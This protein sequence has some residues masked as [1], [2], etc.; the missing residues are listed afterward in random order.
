MKSVSNAEAANQAET[1]VLAVKPQ[2]MEAL[3]AE[4]LPWSP[5]TT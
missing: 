5:P 1:I 3:L 2:D 4:L